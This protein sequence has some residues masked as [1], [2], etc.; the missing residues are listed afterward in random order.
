[1]TAVVVRRN[2]LSVYLSKPYTRELI[3]NEDGTWFARVMELKGCM[4]EGRTEKEALKNLDDAMKGWLEVAIED[5][6]AIPEP[7]GSRS[8]SGKF[9]VR[10]PRTMHRDLAKRA[11]VEGVSLNQMVVAALAKEV[12]HKE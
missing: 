10:V 4:S 5:G 8:F 11:E 7:L 9:V 2:K 6:E 12:G 1:M 3:K